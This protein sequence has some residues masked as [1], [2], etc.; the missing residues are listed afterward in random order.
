MPPTIS[1]QLLEGLT[2]PQR[3]AVTHVDGPMLVLAGPGSGKTRVITR[4]VAYL[5]RHVGI[6]PWNILAIT[7]TNKAAGE[8]RDRVARLVS[9]R[10]GRAITVCTFHSLCARILRTYASRLNVPE[11][12]SIYDTDDQQ[13]AMK[14]AIAEI[15]VNTTNFP[16]SR[17]LG[18]ISQA[19][20]ELLEPE[21]YALS[22]ND[23]YSRAVA[24]LYKAYQ[25]ILKKN[26]AMDFDDL[27]LRTVS[28]LRNE[29]EA[30]EQLRDRF[31]YLLIDEYQ[32]TNHAQFVIANTLA[33]GTQGPAGGGVSHAP[34]PREAEDDP[35]A[36]PP[37]APVVR[38]NLCATGDPDQSIYR[39]RG[40]DIR[41]ILEF[42]EHYPDAKVVRLEQNYR[43]T[44]RILAVADGLIQNNTHRKHKALWTENDE[45][46]KVQVV[47]LREEQHEAAWIVEQFRRLHDDE[48]LSWRDMAVFYRINSLSRVM[49]DALRNNAIPYQIAR[50]T[51]FFDRKEIKDSLGYLRVISNP[52]DE[53]SLLRIINTPARGISDTTVKALQAH[54][55]SSGRSVY[56]LLTRPGEVPG[57]NSRAAGA[58]EK[59]GRMLDRWRSLA[60]YDAAGDGTQPSPS[61]P[62]SFRAFVDQVLRESTLHD[63]YAADTGDTE[64]ERLA[65]LG[66]LVSSAQQF[67][68]DFLGV[69][70]FR[71]NADGSTLEQ[72]RTGGERLNVKL[73]SYLEQVSLVSD[74]DSVNAANGAVTMMT[75][76][77]AKGLEYPVVAVIAVED[78][79]LPH[80]RAQTD[81]RELEEERRLCFVGI[82]RAEKHLFLT[83][84]R[85][86]TVFGRTEPTIPSRFLQELPAGEVKRLNLAKDEWG[87]S[88]SSPVK[89]FGERRHASGDDVD[90]GVDDDDGAAPGGP[91]MAGSAGLNAGDVVRHARFGQGRVLTVRGHGAQT[92]AQVQF[93]QYGVKTLIVEYANLQKV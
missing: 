81:E 7:F 32:D 38:R 72:P 53:V 21:A 60:G 11:S 14:Q 76:H 69:A 13:R 83:H 55:V 56:E 26:N 50:G 17:V 91:A 1:D 59:F 62:V 44:K 24:K 33:S 19:K 85:Y 29:P 18:T 30:R 88:R 20:N 49:E 78:G 52:N 84:A 57:V 23:F 63:F 58:C 15:E 37:M 34:P 16:P 71:F 6:A 22:A 41:N 39:W 70:A 5:V 42:E 68:D 2:D 46:E 66:E 79:L 90:Q 3:E 51:A 80:A 9:E 73:D 36:A 31:Q 77:A 4:R 28:L 45:G 82:T 47:T 75:L 48:G 61:Q 92:R 65:N 74:V 35:F 40:A 43:S 89:L 86:R 67:E 93:N 10:Q 87:S 25:R 27:L 64:N 12:F 54:A 8:M